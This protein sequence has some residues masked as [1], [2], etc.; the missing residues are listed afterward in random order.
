MNIKLDELEAPPSALKAPKE[1]TE[2]IKP[3]I[4]RGQGRP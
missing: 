2:P 1:L 3:T 4:K